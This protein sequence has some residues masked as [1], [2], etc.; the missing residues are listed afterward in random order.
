MS[1]PV[2]LTIIING[3]CTGSLYGLVS[4]AFSFQHGSLKTTNFA[5]G[6]FTIFGS[7]LVF[8]MM[9]QWGWPWFAALPVLL[10]IFFI[11]GYAV[12]ATILKSRDNHVQ[13]VITSALVLI[14]ESVMQLIWT[15][16]SQN[17]LA[18]APPSLNIMFDSGILSISWFRVLTFV[19]STAV[20]VG[21]SIFLKKTWTG[22]AIRA[23]VQN[24]EAAALMGV[25]AD[26]MINVGFAISFIMTAIGAFMIALQFSLEPQRGNTY[27]LIGFLVCL[28]AGL[29]NLKGGFFAGMAVGLL[30]TL[31]NTI[32]LAQFHDPIVFSL[33]VVLLCLFPNGIFMSRKGISRSV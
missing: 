19:V 15:A 8:Q 7:Y 30:S 33:F 9:N 32:G 1:L 21:F 2:L 3:I 27:V 18:S 12:R 11:M 26:K 17:T 31:V 16:M 6:V 13:V 29:G 24:R 23:V 25:N 28:I 14:L 10:V 20:L 5:Y 4:A 22:M